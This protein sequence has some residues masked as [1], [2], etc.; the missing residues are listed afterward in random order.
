MRKRSNIMLL[1]SKENHIYVSIAGVLTLAMFVTIYNTALFASALLVLLAFMLL[2][3][4]PELAL[5]ILFNGTLIYF[6]AVYKLGYQTSTI[7]T[8]LFYMFLGYSFVLAEMLLLTRKHI[9]F[10][11]SVVDILFLLFFL[12]FFLSYFVFSTN[13]DYAYKKLIYA[14]LLAIIPYC[15]GRFLLSE[16]R[17]KNFFKYSVLVAIVLMI[18]VFYGLL[19]NPQLVQTT[20]F[21]M[22]YFENAT[23]P[24]LFG[25]TF[26]ISI[27]IIFVTMFERRKFYLKNLAILAIFGYF[28]FLSGSRGVIISLAVAG[29]V[30]LFI[31]SK[32]TLQTKLSVVFILLVLFGISYRAVPE[33]LT[34]FYEY[35]ISKAALQDTTSSVYLRVGLWQEAISNF[36]ENPIFGIG[37]GNYKRTSNFPHNVILEVAAEFGIL[38]LFIFLLL[39]F[40][41]LRKATMFLKNMQLSHSHTLMKILL[42]LFIY[43]L[44]HTMFSGHIANHTK[45]YICMGAIVCLANIE[46]NSDKLYTKNVPEVYDC[47][48]C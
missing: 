11:V 33:N 48:S 37:M 28:V 47:E 25:D 41:T 6:Y 5:A 30:S 20:R 32:T 19:F 13:N 40:T 34:D 35:S 16:K 12:L 7:L 18:P 31:V 29:S 10:R 43:T 4:K 23:N 21:S 17:L 27:L 1:E 44:T 2:L 8:G 14:P 15:G 36:I 9:V 22:Y 46:I 24:I 26:A 42:V 45:L 39:C 38:G 3:K